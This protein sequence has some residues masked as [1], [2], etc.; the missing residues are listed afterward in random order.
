MRPLPLVVALPAAT[1]VCF[2]CLSLLWADQTGPAVELLAY[3]TVPFGLLMG[4]VARSPFPDWAPRALAR[5]GVVLAALFAAVGLWQAAT[6]ELFFFAA[7]LQ[8]SNANSDYFRVTSLFGDPS[9]YG[10]HLV[11]GLGILLVALAMRRI[12]TLL[13]V[14]LIVLLWAGLYFSYSQSSMI[15]LLAVTLAIAAV[16]GGRRVRRLVLGGILLLLMACAGFVASIEIRGESLRRET[17]DRTQRIEDT[18]RVVREHPVLGV[19][20]GGQPRASRRLSG[21]DR[22]TPVF[23]SHTTPLTVAAEL[24]AV[25]LA[26]YVWLIVGGALVIR[27]VHRLEPALGLTL[28][29]AFL[30][31]FVH[32]LSY[33]GFLEDPV[34]WVVLAVG[35]GYLSWPRRDDGTGRR[36]P[37]GEDAAR[38]RRAAGDPGRGEAA[39][40]GT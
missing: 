30:A 23:V 37:A 2:A 26:L 8:V 33:S 12:N 36:P 4:L 11:L 22:P 24:G 5:L 28:G 39:P 7:N 3:F 40:A 34:T 38:E 15:A 27:G 13:G 31:L 19:G 6:R 29:V 21:R 32:A 10:R 20:I 18:L 9:L 35:A 14:A 25:G 16:T 17:S 1:F